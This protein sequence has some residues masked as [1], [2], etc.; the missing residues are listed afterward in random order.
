MVPMFSHL[1]AIN[2]CVD[3]FALPLERV[4]FRDNDISC[5]VRRS[6]NDR[7]DDEAIAGEHDTSDSRRRVKLSISMFETAEVS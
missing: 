6:R 7:G 1:C 4:P 5:A 3:F 2:V